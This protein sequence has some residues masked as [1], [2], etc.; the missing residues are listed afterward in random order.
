LAASPAKST[1]SA[2]S[3]TEPDLT[4]PTIST[5]NITALMTSAAHSALRKRGLTAVRAELPESQQRAATILLLQMSSL[6]VN[7][8]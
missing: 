6:V 1:A 4:P 5:A 3:D 7:T 2:S 8:L